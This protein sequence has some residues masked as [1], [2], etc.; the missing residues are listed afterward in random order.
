V[1]TALPFRAPAAS[2]AAEHN[3][4]EGLRPEHPRLYLS[5][6]EWKS[7]WQLIANDRLLNRW[8]VTLATAADEIR[9]TPPRTPPSPP[10][11]IAT[12][13]S[14]LIVGEMTTVAGIYRLTKDPALGA[15]AKEEVL[16]LAGYPDWSPESFLACAEATFA[17][18]VGYDWAYELLSP[19]ERAVVRRAII[20]KGLKPGLEYHKANRHWASRGDNW[21]QVCNGGL[22]VGALAIASEEPEVAR[23]L[24]T[25]ACRNLRKALANYDPDG[26][27]AEG[28]GYWH[29][30]SGY[31]VRALAALQSALGTDFS[32]ENSPGVAETGNFRMHDTGAFNY[33]FNFSDGDTMLWP[34]PWMFW[35]A[36]QFN[37]PEYA[38]HE[39][40][41]FDQHPTIFH[42]I[43]SRG[44]APSAELPHDLKRD[45]LFRNIDTACFR[46]AWQ[47]PS[48]AYLGFKCG[49]NSVGHGHLDYGSFVFD[50]QQER[51]AIDLGAEYYVPGYFGPER[52]TFFRASNHSHNTLTINGG[53][54]DSRVRS[55]IV[56]FLS[57]PDR[58]FAVGDLSKTYRLPEKAVRRGCAL[59]HRRDVLVQDDLT[60]PESLDVVWNMF[61]RAET[62]LN[63]REAMLTLRGARM[64]AR[65]LS[66]AK[67]VFEVGPAEAPAGQSQQPD[68]HS[69][70]IHVKT[71]A[72]RTERIAVFL[73]PNQEG[74]APELE[75]LERWIRGF[76]VK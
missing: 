8:F 65:L 29:Y 66:P 32:L 75:P 14:R 2:P 73:T 53:L 58:A 70:R 55:P 61:T 30:G 3:I 11:S 76:E 57:T 6:A 21:N 71:S 46:S 48:A 59:L 16:A 25:S 39:R 12:M 64:H 37:R 5:A 18:A 67:A 49:Y 50:S 19:E 44:P 60:S 62:K 52:W 33:T 40:W 74:K 38:I 51:W 1:W 20:E 45:A 22:I 24:L 47:D 27:W 13:T 28:P 69:L 34:A 42:L 43:W 23:E 9:A 17:E 7:L 56:A 72:G 63:G 15:R 41:A 4:L 35:F 26:G 54:Q 36:R 10:Q 68:V 31:L